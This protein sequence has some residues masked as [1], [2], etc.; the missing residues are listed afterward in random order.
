[1]TFSTSSAACSVTVS[2]RT[3]TIVSAGTCS[4]AA[5]QAGNTNY[6]AAP[7]VIQA[8]TI[9]KA[10]QTIVFGANPGPVAY[11]SGG[12]F[13]VSA[14]GG[15]SGN[16][17]TFSTSSAACSVDSGGRGDDLSAGTCTI[18]ADQAGN[19]N[20]NA[21]PQVTQVVTIDP[22]NQTISFTNPGSQTFSSGG[23]VAL[24]ATASSG[25]TVAFS[26]STTGVCTVSGSTVTMVA[27]GTCTITASQAG[28]GNFNAAPDAIESFGI[29]KLDQT[30]SFTGPPTQTYSSGG[31][32][33]LSA[34]ATSGLTVAFTSTTTS[35]CTVSGTTVSFVSAGTCS[36]T[37]AQAGDGTYN[38]A[39]DVIQAFTIDKADQTI[40]FGAN[41]GP[42][43]YSS[44]GT[45]SVSATGGASGNA[46]TFSTSSA[47]CSVDRAGVVTICRPEPARS[48]PTR[49]GTRITTRR[50]R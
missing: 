40:V 43:T 4:I 24:T 46:V 2:G 36:I 13:S 26:S 12:T 45:F 37:A 25:L 3:V 47:A 28:D 17:V 19:T 50:R 27:P 11:S 34:T 5:A 18:A 39:P 48:P 15:A 29:G 23:T 44:G 9:D 20:Y 31:T 32:V 33:S 49:R 8:F 30:I 1:M 22:A 16:A 41:P 38:A 35:V 42:V 21:A 10:N 14:T 7:E 6:N